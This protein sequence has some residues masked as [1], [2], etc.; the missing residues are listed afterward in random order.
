MIRAAGLAARAATERSEGDRLWT[1]PHQSAG[2]AAAAAR[3]T[4]RPVDDNPSSNV[5]ED[6]DYAEAAELWNTMSQED[7]TRLLVLAMKLSRVV[8]GEWLP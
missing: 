4:S 5:P 8:M 6:P 1:Q 7:R 3:V 2:D